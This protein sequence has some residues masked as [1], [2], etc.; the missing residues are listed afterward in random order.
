MLRKYSPIG[1]LGGLLLIASAFLP[2]AAGLLVAAGVFALFVVA[3]I[4][5]R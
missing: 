5:K 1:A 2:H 3:S 4:L